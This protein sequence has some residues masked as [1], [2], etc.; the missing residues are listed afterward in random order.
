MW[1]QIIMIFYYPTIPTSLYGFV[2][3]R[4]TQ[5]AWKEALPNLHLPDIYE[6]D[7]K[8]CFNQIDLEAQYEIMYVDITDRICKYLYNLKMSNPKFRDNLMNE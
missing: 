6:F 3:V 7:L 8:D 2:T 5:S 1:A 4:G